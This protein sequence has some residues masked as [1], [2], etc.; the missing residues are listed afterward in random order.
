MSRLQIGMI[1]LSFSPGRVT[2]FPGVNR[3]SLSLANALI[4]N[5]VELRVI[6]P[7]LGNVSRTE[8]WGKIEI[9]RLQDSKT[10][11]GRL[12]V[13]AEANFRTFELNLLRHS[14]IFEDC[15]VL[16]TDIPLPRMKMHWR[17]KP[18]VGVVHHVYRVWAGTDLLTVPFGV[19]Y[20]R[21]ALKQADGVVTPSHAAAE[22]T[23][24]VY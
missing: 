12:G 5:D 22:D 2:P 18:L 1:A 4:S 15:D 16:H 6:T 8:I 19:L 20:Q 23:V 7:A 3:Y 17:H 21:R 14:E 24:N 9:T 13:L 11:F 10:L